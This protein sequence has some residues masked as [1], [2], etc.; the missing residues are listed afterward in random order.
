MHKSKV[1]GKVETNTFAYMFI[2]ANHMLALATKTKEG[3]LYNIISCI[4]YCA[5]T[6]EA[7]FN[8]FGKLRNSDWD[9]IERKY[10]KLKK[11][12]RFCKELSLAND[13]KEKPYL[14]MVE[15]FTFRD[16]IAHGKSTVNNINKEII[17]DLEEPNLFVAIGTDWHDY[18]TI[19]NAI[20]AVKDTKSIIL[21]LHQKGGYT[22]DPFNDTGKGI[23]SI[24]MQ[25]T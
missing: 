2:G 4:T 9:N 19:G 1:T 25:K 5:F 14:T 21:E 18:A 12:T 13:L 22:N 6:L 10:S 23:Y 17:I 8:H 16:Q 20:N 11:Y 7:Y 24:T 15:I 3:Q